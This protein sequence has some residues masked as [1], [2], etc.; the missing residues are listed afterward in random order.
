MDEQ[1]AGRRAGVLLHVT[2]LPSGRL[3]DD[4]LRWLDF[5]ASAGLSVWQVLPLV[6]PDSNGSPYQSRSAF[7]MNPGILPLKDAPVNQSDFE[8]YY[9]QHAHWMTRH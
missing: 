7:A 2:S 4:G 5:M 9:V 8:D 3:D 1:T 6:I